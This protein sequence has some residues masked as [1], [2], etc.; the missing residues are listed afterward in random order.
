MADAVTPV[1]RTINGLRTRLSGW[2]KAG[3][4]IALVPT[5]GALHAG[6]L[7]LVRTAKA[8]AERTVVSVFVNPAQFAPT[9]DFAAYP[10]DLPG[11]VGKLAG[12]GVDAVFA[13]SVEE[14]YPAGFAMTIGMGGPAEGLETDFRP[15]FFAG[16]ATVVAK[17]FTAAMPD[18]AVFGEKDYQ[19]LLVVRRLVADLGLPIEIVGQKVI[20]EGDGLA[21]SSRNAYLS[22]AERKIAPELYRT[23]VAAADAVRRNG[24]ADAALEAAR[25]HLTG[26][27]FK[28][29]YVELRD[30]DTL[31]PAVPGSR[32][33]RLLAAARLGRT[34]LIDNIAA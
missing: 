26:A 32:A 17:L 34:R 16:V 7:E 31:G 8:L 18:L 2:R 19:Q 5:M 22:P 1:D 13:P 28:V 12:V 4:R 23:L 14:M 27:G 24:D 6:H 30:A 9:E 15:H 3:D 21:M 29:D 33:L 11:D 25:A 10:R 20:R